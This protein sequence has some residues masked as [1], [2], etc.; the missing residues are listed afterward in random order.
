MRCLFGRYR[1][2]PFKS[3]HLPMFIFHSPY[4]LHSPP[5]RSYLLLPALDAPSIHPAISSHRRAISPSMQHL[6]LILFVTAHAASIAFIASPL[7]LPLAALAKPV[8]RSP[9]SQT[10]TVHHL[11]KRPVRA[12]R[13]KDSKITAATSDGYIDGTSNTSL[14]PNSRPA[15]ADSGLYTSVHSRSGDVNV[16]TVLDQISILSSWH[17]KAR[18]NAQNLSTLSYP[19]LLVKG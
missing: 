11:S 14:Y 8:T 1:F 13:S 10:M 7:V 9:L 17:S 15:H 19:S 18:T 2:A 3:S 4:L 12:P 6:Y 5:L 16:N